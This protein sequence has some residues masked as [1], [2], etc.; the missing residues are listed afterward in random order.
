MKRKLSIQRLLLMVAGMLF[1]LSMQAA[2]ITV[3]GNVVDVKG[4]PIVGASVMVKGSTTGTITD[5]DGNFTL[6]TDESS[7]ISVSYIGF[8]TQE[9]KAKHSI[10][11][12]LKEDNEFLDEVVVVGYGVQKKSALTGAISKVESKDLENRTVISA[13]QALA[14]KTSG[15]QLVSTSGAPGS[16]S[17]VRVRGYSSNYSSEPLYIV[18]GMK[19]PDMSSIDPND[20]ASVEVLKDAASA[21]IYGAEAGNGVVLITT[22]KA[23]E[24]NGRIT[25]DF[26]ISSQSL[27]RLP[28]IL[29]TKEY[30]QYQRE[31]NVLTDQMINTYYDGVTN[32]DWTDVAFENSLMTKHTLA[33]Q[34]ASERTNLYVS[35]NMQTN[36]GIVTGDH[37]KSKRYSADISA[38]AQIKPWLKVGINANGQYSVIDGIRA[39]DGQGG[40]VSSVL[41]MDPTIKSVYGANELPAWMATD[42]QAGMP[43]LKTPG[44]DYYG[45]SYFFRGVDTNPL[46]LRDFYSSYAHQTFIRAMGYVN[47][48]PFKGFVFTSRLG[49]TVFNN[50]N[51]VWQR[52]YYASPNAHQDTPAVTT[53]SPT[54]TSVLFENFANYTR[55]LGQHSLGA[56]LGMSYSD[57]RANTLSGTVNNLNR[58]QAN[59]AY[60]DF[61][62][63]DATRNVS[64]VE[65]NT[66]KLSYFGRL[67]YNYAERYYAEFTMRADGADLSYLSKKKRW[68]YFPAVSLG[69]VP[70]NETWFP[71]NSALSFFKIR[72]SWGQN[73]SLSSLGN[74]AYASSI[75]MGNP[76]AMN[77]HGASA[78]ASPSALGNDNLKWEPSEQLALGSATPFFPARLSLT[79]D[80]FIKKTKDLIIT[81]VTPSYTAGNVPSPLNAGDVE[82]KGFE[83]ELKWQDNIGDFHYS[84]GGNMA[85][86]KNE[87]TYLDPSIMR[88]NGM[89]INRIPGT[90][91][92][93]KG[94]PIWYFRG[95]KF[96]HIDEA[97]GEPVVKD[98]NGD[99]VINSDDRTEIGSGIPDLTYGI[100]LNASYKNFDLVVFGSGA[101]G[102]DI[103]ANYNKL[104]TPGA[105]RL[106]IY[107]D[108]RWTA[109]NHHA[110]LPKP[111]ATNEAYYL[112]S[113]ANIFSGSYFK[114]KQI[115]LGYTLPKQLLARTKFIS[116]LRVYCS[117]D[118]FFIITDYPGMDPETASGNSTTSNG[119]DSGQYPLSKRVTF[120]VNL[121][122]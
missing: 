19:V 67:N 115:Q 30:L 37:D 99:G 48:T 106:K 81:G 5:A 76:Y 64:G 92:F 110:S 47:L 49:A 78:G 50:Y 31:A 71:R 95:F 26:Q 61:Q 65:N 77:N 103:F 62:T 86:L 13:E 41:K 117:L 28:K 114:I 85:T 9:V 122:F 58:D 44:G 20:I 68:G 6:N 107:Y 15:V 16:V 90:T 120:G 91:A 84:I 14:G 101:V 113:D 74:Y 17:S 80:Y 35:L 104:D 100:T 82:N 87:V 56:M 79:A 52:A 22:K 40:V 29:N 27:A 10:K 2:D 32:T 109:D 36:N 46:L 98:L 60:L 89:E 3:K 116:G 1:C 57:N 4:E 70:T 43:V 73:G 88:I 102:N 72:G 53:G 59:F 108:G 12:V 97:T 94:H 21:A 23:S 18:D 83:L 69:W 121:T 54:Y 39:T 118:D 34:K 24:N 51:R 42:V 55:Q 96:D 45:Y 25:Y 11:I 105:N 111:G 33:F 75:Q 112:N 38:D 119:V 7:I 8:V 66:R 93:E 63:A